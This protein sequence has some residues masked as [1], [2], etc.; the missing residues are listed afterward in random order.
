M[1]IPL[2]TLLPILLNFRCVCDKER[3][4]G[5]YMVAVNLWRYHVPTYA[6]ATAL[7]LHGGVWATFDVACSCRCAVRRYCI[8]S[9]A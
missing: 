8:G 5:S 2:P 4:K 1:R 7:L 6:P 3:M 9:V